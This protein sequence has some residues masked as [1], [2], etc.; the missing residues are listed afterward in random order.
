M[1]SLDAVCGQ[2][3]PVSCHNYALQDPRDVC[4]LEKGKLLF[5]GKLFNNRMLFGSEIAA[6]ASE[7]DGVSNRL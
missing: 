2:G 1:T 7:D 5:G 4:V 3:C 6:L